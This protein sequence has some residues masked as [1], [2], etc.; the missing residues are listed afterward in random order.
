MRCSTIIGCGRIM[1][2]DDG[3]G[4]VEKQFKFYADKEVSQRLIALPEIVEQRLSRG[5]KVLRFQ[6]L[7]DLVVVKILLITATRVVSSICRLH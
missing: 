4:E 5:S 6:C 1:V 3:I 2:R 7:S